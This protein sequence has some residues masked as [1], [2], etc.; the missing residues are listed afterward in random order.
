MADIERLA[1]STSDGIKRTVG[2]LNSLAAV[3]LAITAV[4]GLATFS[5]GMWVFELNPAWLVIGGVTCAVPLIA[6]GIAW[7]LVRSTVKLASGLVGDLRTFLTQPTSTTGVL[8]DH[9]S[10]VALGLQAKSMGSLRRELVSRRRELPALF[11]GVRAITGVPGLAAVAVL[12]V[13]FVGALGT[14]LLII[15]L[16]D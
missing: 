3:V 15:G 8:I 1:I 11:A 13:V 14:L 7:F 5:T 4:V 10:G 9:D 16:F 6:A 2:R 12:G